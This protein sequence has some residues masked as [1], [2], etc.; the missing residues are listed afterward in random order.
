MKKE[1]IVRQNDITDCGICCLESIIK[2]YNG[3]VP[4]ETLRLDT[5]TNYTGTSAFN[6]INTAQKYGF[7]AFGRKIVDINDIKILPAI[8]H[9]ELAN[10]LTHFVVIYK[11]TKSSI[12]IMD[13]AKGYKKED[14]KTFLKNW[15]HVILIFKPYKTVPFIKQS[16]SIKSL[17][18]AILNTEKN[19]I[20]KLIFTSAIITIFSIIISYYLKIILSSVENNYITS[21]IIIMI[22]FL[23][24]HIYKIYLN[25]Y[26][27]NLLIYLNKNIDV[28]I[29]LNFINHI[30]KLPLN[31]IKSRTSGEILTRIKEL[32]N[33]KE[34]F[35]EILV[36][37][38]I[39]MILVICSIYFLYTIN[40]KL[41]LIL[42]I[43]CLIYMIVGSVF[44]P[45]IY[46]KLN[47][48]IDIETE[49]N[50][51]L[52]EKVDSIE[53]IKYLNITDKIT[54]DI[55]N[56]YIKYLKN[57]FNYSIFI[58][59]FEAIKSSI[60]E[61]GLFLITSM[62]IYFI[63]TNDLQLL[64]LLTFDSLLYYFINPIENC[65]NLIPKFMLV[66]LSINK[67][68]EFIN[69][70]DEKIGLKE[71]FVNGT[72]KFSNVSYSYDDYEYILKNF[73]INI[74]FKSHLTIQGHSGCGK[75]TLCKMLNR[76]IDDYKGIITI[77]DI[78]IKDYSI[79]TLRSNILYVSQREKLFT[80]SIK[81][82]ILLGKKISKQK[83]NQILKITKVDEI[84][85]NKS[86]RLESMLF[87]S[88]YNL[89]GGER[90]RI[91]LARALTFNPEILIL[92]ESLS[93]LDPEAEK[94][95]LLSLDKYLKDKTLIYISH[96]NHNYLKNRIEIG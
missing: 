48:N 61:I 5:K 34:L 23:V 30:F 39:D 53:S 42:C 13:P 17:F 52:V 3:F 77:N 24:F 68:N 49:F 28:K 85:K 95:I 33:I 46:K 43:I 82:N 35:S 92:D 67:V 16:N 91:I 20:K 14:K 71:Q 75:S 18:L 26:R 2:Y 66:K 76:S 69:I 84:I 12:Y 22:I 64:S 58:N 94:N 41:F 55:G 65:I 4:L 63:T 31:I 6:L 89:S 86:F 88:G 15:T 87:D 83:L 81:E 38:F 57:S 56:K 36:T 96:S 25:H 54:N 50:S 70:D 37:L 11:I 40:N 51:D 47:D 72:I 8:A 78:N 93:E 7:N 44:G 10:G 59:K 73:N 29:I 32:N 27:N 74:P 1:F 45:I 80:A 60:H 62:G 21:T 9:L 79:N 19:L 90:Q